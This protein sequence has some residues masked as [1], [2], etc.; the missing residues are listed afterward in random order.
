MTTFFDIDSA[1]AALEEVGPLL[2]TLAD[3]RGRFRL[4]H[5]DVRPDQDMA[6]SWHP[7][8]QA[9]VDGERVPIERTPIGTMHGTYRF[10]RDDG[11][12]FDAVIAPF[13][14]ASPVRNE[15]AN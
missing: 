11:T 14:L 13:S 5:L 9:T 3:Q 10:W 15:E 8:W 6:M 2:A 4:W 7:R 1:N 12:Y